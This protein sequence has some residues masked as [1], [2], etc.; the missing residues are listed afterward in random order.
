MNRFLSK[1]VKSLPEGGGLYEIF[2]KA[3]DLEKKGKR[4]IHM[5]IGRPDFD[6]PVKAKEAAIKALNEGFV[7]YTPMSGI[8]GLKKAISYKYKKERNM[9][10]D[11]NDELTVTAGACEALLAVMMSVLEEDDEILI[12]SPYFT[13]YTDEVILT[14]AKL[15]EIPLRIE[16]GFLIDEKD[17]EKAITKKTKA[18]LINSPHNPTGVVFNRNTLEK[19]AQIAI[20]HDLLVISDECYDAFVFEGKHISI[21]DID[22]MRERTVIINSTSKVFSMTGWRIGYAIGPKDIIKHINNVHK[23]MSTCATSFAQVGAA[24]AFRSGESFTLDM[25]KEFKKRRD[26]VVKHLDGIKGLEYVKPA[27]AF[28]VFASIKNLNMS[29]TEFCNYILDEA[30]VAL[31]PGDAFGEYGKGFIRIAYA[32]SYSDIEQAMVKIKEAVERLHQ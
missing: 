27:G 3:L 4:I 25:V 20:K 17:I 30:C 28:Y 23:N 12:P 32:C 9:D 15:V 29:S 7:H 31:V 16:N 5:E 19:I 14:G 2:Q 26:L 18:I 24:E 6:S 21:A 10:I 11:I 8:D 13:G 22:N 1:R